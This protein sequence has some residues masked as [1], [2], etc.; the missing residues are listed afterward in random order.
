MLSLTGYANNNKFLSQGL[1]LMSGMNVHSCTFNLSLAQ[2]EAS[3][4]IGDAFLNHKPDIG[5]HASLCG[6]P[7]MIMVYHYSFATV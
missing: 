1:I 5:A 3:A 6:K 4:T 2:W 7:A